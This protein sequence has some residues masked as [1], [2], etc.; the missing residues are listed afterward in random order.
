[1]VRDDGAPPPLEGADELGFVN[2]HGLSRKVSRPFAWGS[3][4][5]GLTPTPA[6]LRN[7]EGQ[8]KKVGRRLHRRFAM[9]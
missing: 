1:M 4:R 8:L 5:P 9:P 7:G 6:H 2:R 3:T